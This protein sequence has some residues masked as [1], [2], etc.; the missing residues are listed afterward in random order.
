MVLWTIQS[1]PAWRELREQ[2]VLRARKHHLTEE[3][4]LPAYRWMTQQMRFKIGPPPEADC[5][6]MWARYQWDGARKKPD[7]A[8]PGAK[9]PLLHGALTYTERRPKSVSS[10][11]ECCRGSTIE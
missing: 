2:G 10:I 9:V 3:S 8:G 5:K 11:L 4:W 1:L 6:A 7:Y